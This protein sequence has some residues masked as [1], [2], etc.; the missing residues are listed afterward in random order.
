MIQ[1]KQY[2]L[3]SLAFINATDFKG[4]KQIS[5]LNINKYHDDELDNII[6]DIVGDDIDYEIFK[7][8]DSGNYFKIDYEYDRGLFT[9]NHEKVKVEWKGKK[10]VL[11]YN[12]HKILELGEGSIGKIS[13]KD[14]ETI[15]CTLYNSI[16]V[17]VDS[18]DINEEHINN[19]IGDKLS[20]VT[21]ENVWRQSYYK[22]MIALNSYLETPWEFKMVHYSETDDEVM[23]AYAEFVKAYK[24]INN[25]SNSKDAYD[26]SD[27]ILYK[28]SEASSIAGILNK[29]ADECKNDPIQ[30]KQKYLEE[31]FKSGLC[32]GISLKQ[33]RGAGQCEEFNV[34]VN[35]NKI[36][37]VDKYNLIKSDKQLY[38]KAYGKFLLSD[39]TDENGKEV[40]DEK[41]MEVTLRQ[42]GSNQVAVDVNNG[43]PAL[44]KCPVN[45]WKGIL[46][47][48]EVKGIKANVEKAN[49]FLNTNPQK[50]EQIKLIIQGALKEGGDCL[51]FILLH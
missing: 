26:P 6:K 45:V 27:V 29:C 13:T 22:Q 17:D 42:F 32:R 33:V 43:G 7:Y 30:A 21:S 24:K 20:G 39:I 2:I 1:L 41:E 5:H 11:S 25:K 46:D 16:F 15:T 37:K 10:G 47:L 19:I 38:I 18:K 49:E 44:G 40:K 3:E 50:C 23:K 51:P 8:S 48:K 34:G 31:L 9:I 12:N 14:Q 35:S 28:K 4:L 36:Q